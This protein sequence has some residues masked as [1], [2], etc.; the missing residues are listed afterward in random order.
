MNW[1]LG[2]RAH[3]GRELAMLGG[4]QSRHE[5]AV[6]L[7]ATRTRCIAPT[8]PLLPTS[9]LRLHACDNQIQVEDMRSSGHSH[10]RGLCRGTGESLISS[11]DFSMVGSSSLFS[12][13]VCGA[14]FG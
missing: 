10:I 13:R 7:P 5:V 12:S 2:D 4:V 8:L 1:L 3:L 14:R 6:R 11:F 9:L